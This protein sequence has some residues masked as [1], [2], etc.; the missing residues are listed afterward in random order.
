MKN[1]LKKIFGQKEEKKNELF[2]VVKEGK[3]TR[4]YDQKMVKYMESKLSDPTPE[5]LSLLLEKAEKLVITKRE[6]DTSKKEK[7]PIT[8]GGV[9][10]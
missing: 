7:V 10:Q 8:I 9:T 1:W 5:T 6:T 4:I 2:K 3:R